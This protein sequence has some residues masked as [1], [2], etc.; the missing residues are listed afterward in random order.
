MKLF[1]ALLMAGAAVTVAALMV[2]NPGDSGTLSCTG[3]ELIIN[4]LDKTNADYNCIVYTPVP[5]PTPSNTE[6]YV[7][8]P[9]C[10]THDERKWHG[11]WN[12]AEGCHYD[13][14]HGDNPHDVD[15]IFGTGFF[16]AAGGEIS[17]PWQTDGENHAHHKHE[18]YKW[19]VRR[20]LPC[21]SQ[22]ATGCI[23]AFRAEAH[24]D[25]HNVA[26]EYHSYAIEALV[27]PESQPDN[28]GIVRFGG[29]QAAGDLTIDNVVVI[30][31]QE[32]SRAPRPVLL[33]YDTTGSPNFATWYPV[34]P[35]A[36]VRIATQTNDM[37]GVYHMP[38]SV[39]VNT[40]TL[41]QFD[42]FCD[43]DTTTG[44]V[45]LGCESN[46]SII[47]PHV[48]GIAVPNRFLGILDSDRDGVINYQ[49]YVD[50]YGTFVNNCTTVGLDCVPISF[51]N[52]I[53]PSDGNWQYRGDAREYDVYF[54]NQ[55]SNWIK[56]PN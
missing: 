31:R 22:F 44:E 33:H 16:A 47:E 36:I 4:I 12:S 55:P 53:V 11:I 1:L 10:A 52:V 9:L 2:L 39:P 34:S 46:A 20:D 27:C 43:V 38:A 6:P 21:D 35:S 37:W 14:T 25:L 26:S 41:D 17:Y 15:D 19:F 28:C 51:E 3:D 24:S 7:N 30:N 13:H 42:F 5:E 23:R 8:A 48:I 32:P 50:R 18:A 49:G 54:D 29:W 45:S 40:L 56:W